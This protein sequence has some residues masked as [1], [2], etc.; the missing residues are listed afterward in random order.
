MRVLHIYKTYFPETQGGLQESIRQLCL[1]TTDQG[2]ENTIFTLARNPIP[3]LLDLPEGTLVRARSWFEI[4]SCDFGGWST[5]KRCREAAKNCD[6]IQVHFPWPFADLILPLIRHQGQL[7]I[8]TY[9]SDVVRQ[10]FLEFFY[11]PFR[12]RLLNSASSIV[13]ST[14]NY[15]HSSDVLKKFQGKLTC[16]PHCIEDIS[17]ESDD[18]RKLWKNRL[19]SGFFLFVGVLR[20]YKGLEFLLDAAQKVPYPIV[21]IGDGPLGNELRKRAHQQGLAHVLFLGA[22]P[23]PDKNVL[24]ELCRA[25]VLPSHLRSE[26]FGMT[27]LEGARAGKPLISCEIGTGTSWIN[28][29]NDT[30]LVVPAANAVALA[31][32]MTAL[33]GDDALCARMGAASRQRWLDFFS[34]KVV[35]RMYRTLY[36]RLLRA[37][38]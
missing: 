22:L 11:A 32:A 5:I 23:D 26:A 8:V 17:P 7:V 6:V 16:I 36:D 2:V 38:K 18:L 19:G 35:G 28:R 9:V 3:A 10:K 31:S 14:E 34:P 21:I 15:I 29:H 1:A 4:A 20:Y 27:L 33:A 13:A 12:H 24:F 25:V 37:E 30:G